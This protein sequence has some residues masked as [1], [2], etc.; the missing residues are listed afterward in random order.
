M[1]QL[2]KFR[3]ETKEWLDQNCPPSMRSGADP[4]I[5]VD[6]VWEVEKQNIKIQNQKSG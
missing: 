6:E 1:T 3:K 2:E 5:P 4:S